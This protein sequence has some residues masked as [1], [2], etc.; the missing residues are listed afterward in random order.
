MSHLKDQQSFGLPR[1]LWEVFEFLND[2]L[3]PVLQRIFCATEDIQ[4]HAHSLNAGSGHSR[5][6][7][8]LGDY[9][10]AAT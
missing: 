10:R 1:A 5:C 2:N 3:G 6:E 9:T 8:M 7:R 4:I